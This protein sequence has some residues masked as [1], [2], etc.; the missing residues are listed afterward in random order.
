MLVFF[1]HGEIKVIKDILWFNQCFQKTLEVQEAVRNWLMSPA[2][3]IPLREDITS[4]L[5]LYLW[6]HCFWLDQA[7]EN[8]VSRVTDRLWNYVQARSLEGVILILEAI[9]PSLTQRNLALNLSISLFPLFVFAVGGRSWWFWDWQGKSSTENKSFLVSFAG[10]R[11]PF[12]EFS[13][14]FSVFHIFSFWSPLTKAV[15][16]IY[17]KVQLM[18]TRA[19]SLFYTCQIHCF[20]TWLFVTIGGFQL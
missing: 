6:N 12:F 9:P 15:S 7:K 8:N 14:R 19:L 4:S 10:N 3:N 16:R 17:G 11:V 1:P 20:L 5:Y 2:F 13:M 18:Q